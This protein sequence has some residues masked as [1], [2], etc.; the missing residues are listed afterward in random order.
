MGRILS[1]LVAAAVLTC[2]SACSDEPIADKVTGT[3]KCNTFETTQY[4]KNG[5]WRD[6]TYVYN[7]DG[8]VVITRVDDNTVDISL[9]S[10]RCGEGSAT[11]VRLTDMN[12]MANLSGNGSF[13]LSSTNFSYDSKISGSINYE[14][15]GM[16]LSA[17]LQ[18]VSPRHNITFNNIQR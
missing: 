5:K 10:Q 9:K 12:Y 14:N 16:S 8:K 6:T 7:N 4:Q 2:L 11:G 13:T 15:K 17:I 18:G 3:Y 1:T